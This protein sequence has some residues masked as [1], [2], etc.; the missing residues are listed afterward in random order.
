[1]VGPA[2]VAA[3]TI[4]ARRRLA[5][6]THFVAVSSAVAIYNR[7]DRGDVPFEVIPNFVPDDLIEDCPPQPTGPLLF[8]GDLSSQKGVL[9]L[10]DAYRRLTNPPELLLAGRKVPGVEPELTPGMRLVGPLPHEEVM[11]LIA[12]ARLMVVPSIM[13]DPCPTVVLEAMGKG[14]PVV[15]SANGGITDMV[16]DRVTGLLVAPGDPAALA[17]GISSILGDVSAA[18]AMGVAARARVRNFT[19]SAVVE[20]IEAVYGRSIAR[21]A[22]STSRLR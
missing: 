1:M 5:N 13:P 4:A 7:L 9:V 3:N 2:T 10:V 16:E 15:A 6:V 21:S 19:A 14:R 12:S 20:R 22:G 8:V 17:A 18:R 11:P